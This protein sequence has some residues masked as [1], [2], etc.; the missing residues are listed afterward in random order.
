MIKNKKHLVQKDVKRQGW[1]SEKNEY[2]NG[3][4]AYSYNFELIGSNHPNDTRADF[5]AH[6]YFVD[7]DEYGGEIP[8]DKYHWKFYAR[9]IFTWDIRRDG[10][11]KYKTAEETMMVAEKHLKSYFD[12]YRNELYLKLGE[13][14]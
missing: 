5:G 6:V 1:T 10:K 14:V 12:T 13:K 8:E 2:V 3:N 4:I 11:T 9:G 7:S